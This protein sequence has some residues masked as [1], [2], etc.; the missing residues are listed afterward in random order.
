MTYDGLKKIGHI[1]IHRDQS[2][3]N[4]HFELMKLDRYKGGP[5]LQFNIFPI[6]LIMWPTVFRFY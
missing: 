6:L 1:C 4:V 2:L 3:L 5:R